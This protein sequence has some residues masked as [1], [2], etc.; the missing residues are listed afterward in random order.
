M[1]GVLAGW[2][3]AYPVLYS[4]IIAMI[5]RR[6]HLPVADFLSTFRAP[7]VCVAIMCMAVYFVKS[8]VFMDGA[9]GR[10]VL[11]I[12]VGMVAYTGSYYLLFREECMQVIRKVREMR[13]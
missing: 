1:K 10:L 3:V 13:K 7:L 5:T 12:A 6:L 9:V 4:F 11:S 8:F 2:F